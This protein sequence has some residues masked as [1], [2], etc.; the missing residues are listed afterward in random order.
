[1]KNYLDER[2]KQIK[3]EIKYEKRRQKVCATGKSD[4]YYLYSLQEELEDLKEK[5][6]SVE[7]IACPLCDEE[8]FYIPYKSKNGK[9]IHIYSHDNT[10]PFIA[11]EFVN[12]EDL[13][14][15][16]EYMK[17]DVENEK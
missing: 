10:C 5:A 1:M 17:R 16:V 13:D 15:F 11:F 4:I 8:L 12:N 9:T 3:N 14:G 6:D 2:I 7:G